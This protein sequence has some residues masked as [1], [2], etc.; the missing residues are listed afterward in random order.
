MVLQRDRTNKEEGL[1]R[2]GGKGG[3]QREAISGEC[4]RKGRR[5]GE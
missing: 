1:K 2:Q 4:Y 5:K 3:L